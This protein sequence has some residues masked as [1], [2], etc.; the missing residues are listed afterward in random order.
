MGEP[1]LT[2]EHV[3]VS[4]GGRE[5]LSDVSLALHAGEVVGVVG[6]SGSGKSTLIRAAMG[7]LGAHGAV[8][9]GSIRFR[10]RELSA[11]PERQMARLRGSELAM[12]FQDSLAALT[13]TRTVG[14]QVVEMAR[15]HE[16]GASRRGALA[17]A[18]GLLSRLGVD[19]PERVLA[20]FP[21]ELSGGLGQR[22]GLM[23][24]LYFRPAVLFA[25]EPTSA[26][27]TVSQKQVV[28][29]LAALS[30]ET[31]TSLLVATH[32]FGVVRAL[33]DRVAVMEA[34]RIVEEGEAASVLA[35]PAAQ[36]TRELLAALPRLKAGE[37][38]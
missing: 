27:D 26:L 15:S 4:Y 16:R 17:R 3:G 36:R 18:E 35:H 33:A 19:D 9:G 8:T 21:S 31:G 10:G 28:D 37:R 22:V 32:N 24:A 1:L 14:A 30:S 6:E 11:L 23:T 12:V 34:G 5:A 13:P 25:D 2:Y 38:P 20:S 7:L 29:E